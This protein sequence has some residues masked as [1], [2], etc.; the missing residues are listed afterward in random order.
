MLLFTNG[1]VAGRRIGPDS[2]GQMRE[3]L[4]TLL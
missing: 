1:S 4:D 2:E 3:F